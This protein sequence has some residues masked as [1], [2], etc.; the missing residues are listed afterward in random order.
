MPHSLESLVVEID[1]GDLHFRVFD[2]IHV[3]TETMVLGRD[4][5]LA[6]EEVLDR[7]V[8]APVAEFQFVGFSSQGESQKLLARDRSRTRGTFLQEFRIVS[9]A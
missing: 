7:M 9:T 4:L 6:R 5:D 1:V 8:G 3:H 2:G